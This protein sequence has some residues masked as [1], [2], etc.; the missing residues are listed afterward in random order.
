MSDDKQLETKLLSG[1]VSCYEVGVSRTINTGNYEN[2]RLEVKLQINLEESL[3]ANSKG[4]RDSV[5]ANLRR[6]DKLLGLAELDIVKKVG[7]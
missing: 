5:L 6:A 3:P 2:T 7:T 4:L 1:G